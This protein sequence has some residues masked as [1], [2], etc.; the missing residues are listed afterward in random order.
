MTYLFN[1]GKVC[2]QLNADG[3]FVMGKP[4]GTDGVLGRVFS[5]DPAEAVKVLAKEVSAAEAADL[6]E[7]LEVYDA[8]GHEVVENLK[9]IGW[10]NTQRKS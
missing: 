5:V 9:A 2:L 6:L 3:M 8:I 1:N 10:E 7:W 4:S